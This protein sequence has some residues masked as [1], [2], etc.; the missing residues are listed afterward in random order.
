MIAKHMYIS[1]ILRHTKLVNISESDV[2]IIVG[3]S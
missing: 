2:K 3:F 1:H